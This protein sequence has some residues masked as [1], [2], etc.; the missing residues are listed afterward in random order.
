MTPYPYRS[1]LQF[2]ADNCN[3]VRMRSIFQSQRQGKAL[4]D[5]EG[6]DDKVKVSTLSIR[7][8]LRALWY[9]AV[10]AEENC[11]CMVFYHGGGWV[12]QA[13]S[14]LF[15]YARRFTAAL[16][17]RTVFVDYRLGPKH[18]FPAAVFD[19]FDTYRYI[20][21]HATALCV[22]PQRLFVY[23][24]SA[25]GNLAAAVCLMARDKGLTPPCC[26]ML[27][28]PVTD[29][30]METESFKEY[31]DTPMCSARS[32]R[33]FYR[34]YLGRFRRVPPELLPYLS[35]AEAKNHA[36]LPPAYIET[37]HFDPLR[38]EGR[39]Y[40]ETLRAAG[41]AAVFRQTEGTMHG[42]EEAHHTEYVDSLIQ[43]RIAY[44]QELLYK[45]I[46]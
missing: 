37:A 18:R 44:L 3:P 14:Y 40:A 34:L 15:L 16:R 30:R 23:G 41:V 29:H 36:N 1:E 5:A 12:Y 45:N 9:E 28:Y 38:E 43:G 31:V 11:P 39:A 7:P 10:D 19:A 13:A 4:Y 33:L 42:Y 17:C 21:D 27:I 6:S 32:M 22:D 2:I 20:L 24:D 25:G 35:P 26:Q 46:P 8:D